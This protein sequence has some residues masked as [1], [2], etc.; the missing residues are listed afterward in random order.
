VG[1]ARPVAEADRLL[2]PAEAAAELGVGVKA[3]TLWSDR[4]GIGAVRTPGGH[5]RYKAAE[6]AKLRRKRE[7]ARKARAAAGAR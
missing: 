2:T 6:V 7:R 3:L 5:R 1:K 4:G